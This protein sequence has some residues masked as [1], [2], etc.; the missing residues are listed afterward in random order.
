MKGH[1][2]SCVL[3]VTTVTATSMTG[4]QYSEKE[5]DAHLE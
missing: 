4:Y 3:D 1:Y 2:F 5:V